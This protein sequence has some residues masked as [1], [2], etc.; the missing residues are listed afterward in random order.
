MAEK[1]SL[2]A[3]AVNLF[4]DNEQQAQIAHVLF[5]EPFKR[6]DH[7][8]AKTMGI[9]SAAAPDELVVFFRR[10]EGG[11]G[12]NVSG[13]DDFGCPP[14]SPNVTTAGFDFDL[15][16]APVETRRQ[17][18]QVIEEPIADLLFVWRDRIDVD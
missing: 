10:D 2:G 3:A 7:R 15:L 4:A 9:A 1:T 8:G 16:D 12:V 14:P 17:R 18:T 5:Q 6:L 13:E 11:N